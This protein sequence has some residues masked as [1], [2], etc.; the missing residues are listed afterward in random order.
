MPSKWKSAIII[1]TMKLKFPHPGTLLREEFIRPM[2]VTPYRLA[3]EIGV[4]LTRITAILAGER[5]ITAD[6]GLRLDRYFGLSEGYWLGLQ[7]DYDLRAAKR[8]LGST[9]DRIHPRE[10]A[11]AHSWPKSQESEKI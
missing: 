8:K 3:K 9:L 10:A 5:A 4:P 7:H 1:E 2:A 6:T 11:A